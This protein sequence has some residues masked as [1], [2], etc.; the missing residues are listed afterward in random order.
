MFAL[1]DLDRYKTG[2]FPTDYPA[3]RRVFFAPVDDVH[4]ALTAVVKS[5]TR[6]LSIGMFGWDDPNLQAVLLDKMTDPNIVVQVT[7]DSSQAGGKHERELLAAW[8][9]PTTATPLTSVVSVGR[10]EH[11]AIMHMKAVVVDARFTVTGST[12]WSVGGESAQDNELTVTDSRA[13]AADL[14]HR[15]DRIHLDQLQKAAAKAKG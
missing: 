8:Y 3:D 10:S 15:L 2:G 1:T 14:Q 4:G 6:S 5:A 9:D 12:N 11:G 13:Q 7:L